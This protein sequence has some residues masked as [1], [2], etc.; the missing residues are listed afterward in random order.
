MI[1]KVEA[2]KTLA[3]GSLKVSTTNP[4]LIHQRIELRRRWASLHE[5]LAFT[6]TKANQNLPKRLQNAADIR[7]NSKANASDELFEEKETTH[8][9]TEHGNHFQH[10]ERLF[11]EAKKLVVVGT[12]EKPHSFTPGYTETH[13]KLLQLETLTISA[14]DDQADHKK[15]E[16]EASKMVDI[17]SD[18]R[19]AIT[20]LLESGTVTTLE[21]NG[22]EKFLQGITSTSVHSSSLQTLLTPNTKGRQKTGLKTIYTRKRRGGVFKARNLKVFNPR[23]AWAIAIYRVLLIIRTVKAASLIDTVKTDKSLV[24]QLK[25][26]QSQTDS[27][28]TAKV[29]CST[30][31]LEKKF[32]EKLI[33]LASTC[34]RNSLS[35]KNR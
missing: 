24:S 33:F 10:H 8:H 18:W 11:P 32:F 21:P 19:R 12:H 25:E 6:L 1:E 20:Q 27:L 16:E 23:M 13:L 3:S 2:H 26:F 17:Q 22:N 15:L 34:T 31:F 14:L 28:T 7:S 5:S 9:L 35:F 30:F 29:S 4:H